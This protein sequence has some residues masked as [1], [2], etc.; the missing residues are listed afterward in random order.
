M[1]VSSVRRSVQCIEYRYAPHTTYW[2]RNGTVYYALYQGWP[3]WT[4]A[5]LGWYRLY[6]QYHK[7]INKKNL[8]KFFKKRH[9]GFEL[10][11]LSILDPYGTEPLPYRITGRLI[12]VPILVWWTLLY[13]AWFDTI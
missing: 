3:N 7:V 13:T 2:Y 4:G 6:N 9:A 11:R 10:A 1:S 8:K 12:W 5:K